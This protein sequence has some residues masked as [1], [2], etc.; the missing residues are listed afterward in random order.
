MK[1]LC[2]ICRGRL[3]DQRKH[4]IRELLPDRKIIRRNREPSESE[5]VTSGLGDMSHLLPCDFI[6]HQSIVL[7]APATAI[8]PRHG[9]PRFAELGQF[10]GQSL[11]QSFLHPH[12]ENVQLQD[13]RRQR[14][15]Q[16]IQFFGSGV[17]PV[18]PDKVFHDELRLRL[19]AGV[20]D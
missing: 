20:A 6:D 4:R 13:E 8:G 3:L 15:L 7:P 16:I 11:G 18:I 5:H 12:F 14:Q 2:I 10:F 17:V 19:E 9:L 1:F